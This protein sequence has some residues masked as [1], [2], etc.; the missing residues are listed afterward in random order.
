[1]NLPIA[2]KARAFQSWNQAQY[3]SLLRE[4]QM[5][6]KTYQ[7]VRIRAQV[8]LAQLNHGI[9]TASGSRINQPNRFHGAKAQSVASSTRDLLNW[10]TAF[11][12]VQLLPFFLLTGLRREQCIIQP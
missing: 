2:Q 4:F 1:M 9:G 11:K 6:L 3:T 8:L 5:V 12:V 10:Q 7:V